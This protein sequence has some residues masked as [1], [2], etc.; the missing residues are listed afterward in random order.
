MPH[1]PDSWTTSAAANIKEADVARH[2]DVT[3]DIQRKDAEHLSNSRLEAIQVKCGCDVIRLNKA[4]KG[5]G[6]YKLR[7][8]GTADAVEYAMIMVRDAIPNI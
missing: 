3:L 2:K 6:P 1:M 5:K 4:I 8:K 7:I